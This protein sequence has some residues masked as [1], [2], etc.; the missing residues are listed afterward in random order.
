MG[1]G[2]FSPGRV[3]SDKERYASLKDHFVP[4]QNHAHLTTQTTQ[5]LTK[6]K[7]KQTYTL[8][9]HYANIDKG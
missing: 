9:F 8:K 1:G 4:D 2:G 6:G 5:T 7:R 3:L